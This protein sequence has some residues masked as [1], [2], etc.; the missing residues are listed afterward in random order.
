M[1]C[2]HKDYNKPFQEAK[3]KTDAELVAWSKRCSKSKD[4]AIRK[5]WEQRELALDWVKRLK[6]LTR[7]AR[8]EFAERLLLPQKR[9]PKA[10]AVRARKRRVVLRGAR[11]RPAK[12]AAPA[13]KRRAPAAKPKKKT[14]TAEA[15]TKSKPGKKARAKA[16]AAGEQAP[17]PESGG[18]TAQMGAPASAQAAGGKKK[19]AAGSTKPR[20]PKATSK[21]TDN[22]QDERSDEIGV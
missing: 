6:R 2:F 21:E 3:K 10:A 16:V 5:L 13:R 18:A 15:A 17:V 22:D 8:F 11:R 9:A 4:P 14:A 7:E 19:V 1:Y 20:K 12:R